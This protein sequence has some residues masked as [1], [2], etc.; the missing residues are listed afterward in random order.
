MH[1]H[2]KCGEKDAIIVVPTLNLS[3]KALEGF[4][5]GSEIAFTFSGNVAHMFD[6]ESGVNLEGA[7][8]HH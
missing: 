4:N 2:V 7:L 6:H 8:Q 3:E 5:S 1:L